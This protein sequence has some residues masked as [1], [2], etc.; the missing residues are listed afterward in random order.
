M[1]EKIMEA[2]GMK[3][4]VDEYRNGICPMCKKNIDINLFTDEL[5]KREYKISGLCQECQDIIFG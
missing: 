4:M 1:N 2:L 5:S 3:D